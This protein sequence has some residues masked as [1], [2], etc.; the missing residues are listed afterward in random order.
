MNQTFARAEQY[1]YLNARPLD[2]A[3]W[4]YHFENGSSGQ[5]VRALKFYQNGDGGF[6]H[7][8]EADSWNPGSSPI[9]TWAATEILRECGVTER[10]HPVIQGILNYLGSGKDLDGGFWRGSVPGNNDYPHAPWWHYNEENDSR[11]S[12]NPAACLA[13]FIVRYA[14]RD[15]SLYRTGCLIARAA[16][17]TCIADENETDM[18]TIT[19]YI[20]LLQYLKEA[21]EENLINIPMLQEN[22]IRK[23]EKTITKDI[24][25]WKTSYICRPSQYFHNRESIFFSENREIAEYECDYIQ[26]TQLDDGSWEIPWSWDDYPDEWAVS[27]N[28]WKC[29]RIIS[30]I[31]YLKGMGKLTIKHE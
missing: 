30:N 8:L 7:A 5:I 29:D 6:G 14:R 27:R 9:Q 15:S 22:L 18:H 3:R 17:E 26:E 25:L 16:F 11:G 24:S 2:L 1:I 13:G 19:C 23:V 4:Q 21:G 10:D 31:R 20:R 28:W 12:Y